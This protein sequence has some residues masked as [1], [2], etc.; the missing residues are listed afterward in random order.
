AVL[1]L[2]P[3][4][5]PPFFSPAMA[6]CSWS[7]SPQNAS[8]PNVSKRKIC[9]PSPIM[10]AALLSIALSNPVDATPS[11][12]AEQCVPSSTRAPSATPAESVSFKG[13]RVRIAVLLR[14]HRQGGNQYDKLVL[15]K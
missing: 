7:A 12:W 13:G 2:T 14:A 3:G 1:G 10:R 11:A 8:S 15:V 4:P 9:R 5:T 6:L